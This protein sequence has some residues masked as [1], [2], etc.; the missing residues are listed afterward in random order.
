MCQSNFNSRGFERKLT[1]EV[2]WEGGVAALFS[3]NFLMKMPNFLLAFDFKVFLPS[4]LLFLFF[5]FLS[6]PSPSLLK[7]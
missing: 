3:G 1:W 5:P 6:P 7:E 2:E 4:P